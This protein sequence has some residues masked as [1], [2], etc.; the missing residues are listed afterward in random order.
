MSESAK[1]WGVL[2]LYAMVLLALVRPGSPGPAFVAD[3]G[4]AMSALVRTA[5]GGKIPGSAT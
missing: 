5:I 1:R 3:I 4:T 2:M